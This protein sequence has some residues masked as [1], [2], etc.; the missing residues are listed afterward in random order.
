MTDDAITRR[1]QPSAFHDEDWL[2]RNEGR[3][4]PPPFSAEDCTAAPAW[5][6][7]AA[8][9]VIASLGAIALVTA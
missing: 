3:A 5:L 6:L 4:D 7:W 9:I 1:V 8:A 2:Y